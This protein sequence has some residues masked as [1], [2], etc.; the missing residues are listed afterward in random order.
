M[1]Q[2]RFDIFWDWL[3]RR[4]KP[5]APFIIFFA[6]AYLARELDNRASKALIHESPVGSETSDQLLI[7]EHPTKAPILKITSIPEHKNYAVIVALSPDF[8]SVKNVIT[9]LRSRT[10]NA[11]YFPYKG[12]FAVYVNGLKSRLQAQ[13]ALYK[14]KDLGYK[15]AHIVSPAA[16]RYS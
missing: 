15:N 12:Q 1:K 6:I 8:H 9:E 5:L 13:N 11:A 7:L 3:G 2:D 16:Q 10:I 4:T 14:I